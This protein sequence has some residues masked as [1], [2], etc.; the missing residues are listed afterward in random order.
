MANNQ[1]PSRQNVYRTILV[2]LAVAAALPL[3]GVGVFAGAVLAL[4]VLVWLVRAGDDAVRNRLI[5]LAIAG[6][7][8]IENIVFMIGFFR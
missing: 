8:L 4:M 7:V 2:L 3:L 5:L 6:L 1:A